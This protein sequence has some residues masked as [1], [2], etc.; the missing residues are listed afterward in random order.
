MLLIP[1]D[2]VKSLRKDDIDMP[3][4]SIAD[5]LL[6]AGAHQRGAA[7]PGI[8]IGLDHRPAML[9]CEALAKPT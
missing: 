8:G 1:A 4:T 6:I 7:D 9:A 2:P 5:H 3:L